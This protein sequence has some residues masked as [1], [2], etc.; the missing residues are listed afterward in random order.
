MSHRTRVGHRTPRKRSHISGHANA[1]AGTKLC[2]VSAARPTTRKPAAISRVE[3]RSVPMRTS[4]NPAAMSRSP[5]T[6]Y[7]AMIGK[8]LRFTSIEPAAPAAMARLQR[9]GDRA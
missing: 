4:R 9:F 1:A 2:F 3:S 6:V 7:H 8:T 5:S